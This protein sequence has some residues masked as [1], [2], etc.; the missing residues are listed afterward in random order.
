MHLCKTGE[1]RWARP[2]APLARGSAPRALTRGSMFSEAVAVERRDGEGSCG[3]TMFPEARGE[4]AAVLR[5]V[6]SRSV[7]FGRRAV[8][9][10][11]VVFQVGS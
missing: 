1:A 4:S 6:S 5:H 3:S 11:V 2:R 10:R 9:M 8:E 7:S